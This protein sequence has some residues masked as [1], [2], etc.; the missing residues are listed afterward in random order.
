VSTRSRSEFASGDTISSNAVF[1]FAAQ[2]STA[3]FTA[4]ITVFLVRELGPA[5]YGIFAL[6]LSIAALAILP[7]DLGV[8]WSAAR[9]LAEHR[10]ERDS[11]IGVI[12]LA[13]RVK[14]IAGLV[15]SA[16]LF[17]LAGP[18]A[19]GYGVPELAWPIRAVAVA[20]FA[21]AL[22]QFIYTIFIAVRRLSI[23]F[24]I[25]IS[26]SAME[27]TATVAFVLT[28]GGAAGAT[29]GRAVGYAFGAVLAMVMLSRMIGGLGASRRTP[30]PVSA[31]T[32][33]TYAGAIFIIDTAFTV[34][35]QIDV[36]LIGSILGTTAA[37]LYSAPLQM[38]P[39]LS[40][41]GLA[42]ARAV[43]PT[44]AGVEGS[45]GH[46]AD[47]L[48]SALRLIVIIQ[49]LLVAGIVV[50]ADP[51]VSL[52]LGPDYEESVTVLRALA[53]FVFLLG[54]APLV[55]LPI[56][57]AGAAGRRVPIALGTIALNVVLDL[58]FIPEIGIVAGAWS[59]DIS[60]LLYVAAHLWLC[61]TML[62]VRLGPIAITLGRCAIA[63]L[64]T[65]AFLALIGT[66]D[67]SAIEWIAGAALAPLVYAG[68]LIVTRELSMSELRAAGGRLRSVAGRG[69]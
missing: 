5:E 34:F 10:H 37:G 60:F 53:P 7:S 30:S 59:T 11:V 20:M 47:A 17:A 29:W 15:V 63:A 16:A 51:I 35:S 13:L 65:A 28:V 23:G 2:L 42:L 33:L 32:F 27:L 31:R 46:S 69:R 4:A 50:W 66:A 57:F 56:N 8:S 54:M 6:A 52:T 45:S 40:Y 26:E 19:D 9:F 61:H 64:C 49:V 3:A 43:A 25:V 18:I 12:G 67:L 24:R 38:I 22:M 55:S 21:Q 39:F 1:A 68:V 48:Q 58:I 41:P 14:V 44:A 36:L 62:G